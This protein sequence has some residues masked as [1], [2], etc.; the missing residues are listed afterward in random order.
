MDKMNKKLFTIKHLRQLDERTDGQDGRT[1]QSVRNGR[2]CP[3]LS[4]RQNG[5]REGEERRQEGLLEQ[6]KGGG[7]SAAPPCPC[8]IK[9]FTNNNIFLLTK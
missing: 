4:I 6:R 8:L 7:D 3:H 1:E 9:T 2:W 5:V